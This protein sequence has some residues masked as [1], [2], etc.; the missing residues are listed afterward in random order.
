MYFYHMNY[1][2]IKVSF[3]L[4]SSHQSFFHHEI[5]QESSI[6]LYVH[7]YL[8]SEFF[9]TS[10]YDFTHVNSKTGAMEPEL[11]TTTLLY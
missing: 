8:F 4:C 10:K 7:V 5:L 1:S 3:F 9:E 11:Q 2:L 6:H